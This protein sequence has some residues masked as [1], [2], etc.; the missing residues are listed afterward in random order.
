MLCELSH[1]RLVEVTALSPRWKRVLKN[2]DGHRRSFLDLAQC[3]G[4]VRC[5]FSQHD[6][7]RRQDFPS[8]AALLDPCFAE[9]G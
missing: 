4:H 6:R 9:I 3:V 8:W 7:S 5:A 2:R 1:V